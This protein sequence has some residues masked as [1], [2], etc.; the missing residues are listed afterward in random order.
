M[1]NQK[2][3]FMLLSFLTAKLVAFLGPIWIAYNY[4]SQFYGEMEYY[5]SI[6]VW[7]G[8]LL[9]AGIPGAIPVRVIKENSFIIS[10]VV[11]V[12]LIFVFLLI[13]LLLLLFPGY[14]FL[15]LI[16]FLCFS[17]QLIVSLL[18]STRKSLF[19][20]WVENLALNIVVFSSVLSFMLLNSD[21][22]WVS[23]G[24]G[25]GSFLIVLFACIKLYFQRELFLL[26]GFFEEL[27]CSLKIGGPILLNGIAMMGVFNSGRPLFGLVFGAAEVATYAY[28]FRVAGIG[29]VVYQFFN[30]VFFREFYKLNNEV[31]SAKM[32]YLSAFISMAFVLVYMFFFWFPELTPSS[33]NQELLLGIF[34]IVFAQINFWI[35]GAVLETRIN[36]NGM[37]LKSLP[38]AVFVCIVLVVS[39]SVFLLNDGKSE[40]IFCL[41]LL[42]VE[43]IGVGFQLY[44]LNRDGCDN[45]KYKWFF[46]GAILPL[47]FY[48]L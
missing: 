18:K 31:V 11:N 7:L 15:L 30:L 3:F 8:M 47:I 9:G 36:A 13:F 16:V 25:I 24:M 14:E 37:T 46:L 4:N 10:L 23:W 17:Q 43:I 26:Q 12:L 38:Y 45:F 40:Y 35:F 41:V 44:I 21:V 6:G 5:L 19:T 32:Q 22:V 27:W 34:P 20:P 42:I 28:A 39:I 2:N 48:F 29:Y 1:L 33:L